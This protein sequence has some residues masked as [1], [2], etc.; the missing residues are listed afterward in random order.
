MKYHAHIYYTEATREDALSVHR[1]VAARFPDLALS[2]LVDYAV[3]PHLAPM[4]QVAFGEELLEICKDFF[5][6]FSDRLSIMIHPLIADDLLA[7]TQLA[8]WLG[9]PLPVNEPFLRS[10]AG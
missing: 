5:T 2:P 3:G 10:L 4:F 1:Q 8:I 7:H 9:N 6:P